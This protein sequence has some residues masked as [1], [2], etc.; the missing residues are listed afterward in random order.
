M[1]LSH[2]WLKELLPHTFSTD[3][4]AEK[5][6][7][8]GL[9]V[10]GVHVTESIKGGLKGVVIG[11]VITCGKHPNADKLSLTTVDVGGIEPLSIVCGAPNVATGQKVLVATVGTELYDEDGKAFQIKEAKVRG[12]LSQGMICAEDELGLGKSHEGIMIL[13]EDTQ[14]GMKASDYFKIESDEV[15]EIGLTP[16]RADA[17]SHFGAARDLWATLN[18]HDSYD[19]PL[20]PVQILNIEGKTSSPFKVT[21]ENKEACKRY[22]GILIENISVGESPDWMKNRLETIGQRAVNSIVDIT[23]YVMFELGQPLHAFDADKIQGQHIIVKNLPKDSTFITLDNNT[24]A[25]HEDDLIICDEENNPMCIA[26]VYGGA[27]SGVTKDTKNIFLESAWFSPTSVR[28]TSFRHNLRTES[29]SH[30]EKGTDPHQ[31]L[32]ALLRA[33]FLITEYSSG[34][35]NTQYIDNFPNPEPAVEVTID[36]S[37]VRMLIGKEISDTEIENTLMSLS[38]KVNKAD[39]SAWI[40]TV[41]T[42]KTDVFRPADIIEEIVRIFGFNNIEAAEKFSFAMPDSVRNERMDQRQ[43]VMQYLAGA[44]YSEAMGLSIINSV[45]WA[46]I[47]GDKEFQGV[48]INNTSNIQLDLMRPDPIA[49][50]LETIAYNQSRQQ[51]DMK[52]FEYGHSYNGSDDKSYQEESFISIY[53]TGSL[54]DESWAVLNKESFNPYYLKSTVTNMFK[55]LNISKF[56]E[57]AGNDLRFESSIEYSMGPKKLAVLGDVNQQMLKKAGIKGNMTFAHIYWDNVLSVV[58]NKP[59]IFK[60]FSRFPVVRRDLAVVVAD[61]ITY[62]EIRI[63]A[64]KS[65]SPYLTKIRLFDNYKSEEHLGAGKKSLSIALIFT[66][67][68]KTFEEK[69]IDELMKKLI[70]TLEKKVD[71]VIRK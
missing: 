35:A 17:N 37:R 43:L 57:K 11:K 19:L 50:A 14:I 59:V 30:F 47:T 29:A 40:V 66:N 22:T 28:K 24:K 42:H 46:K 5:L 39:Q 48:R 67:N 44:G 7:D 54:W 6:T 2:N 51:T 16:N 34:Q 9:E 23:N 8:I 69:E 56:Q 71:A 62:E 21:I 27:D 18:L 53:G 52:M 41:P 55:L 12:E 38:M 68:E 63:L 26:G 45:N 33:A 4:I 64:Q 65:L 61:K 20:T 60:E 15:I 1:K 49:T 10:E 25:L 36:P 13:P 3:E 58:N 70:E 32:E 31:C